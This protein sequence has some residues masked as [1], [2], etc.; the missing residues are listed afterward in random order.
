MA[1]VTPE[2]IESKLREALQVTHVQAAD[3]SDGCG[4]KFEVVVVSPV[5][6]GAC[7]IPF[8]PSEGDYPHV[9]TY[10]HV[11]THTHMPTIIPILLGLAG[12][13]LLARHREVNAALAEELKVIHAITLKCLTP[14][15]WEEKQQ[16]QPA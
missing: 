11:P 8:R 7:V 6:A 14:A 2:Q 12:K 9:W 16:Q 1:I 5:F 13:A 4:A 10:S 15:Q 3:L